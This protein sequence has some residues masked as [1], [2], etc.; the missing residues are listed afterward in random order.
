MMTPTIVV[1]ARPQYGTW[2][3]HPVGVSAALLAAIAGTK[4]LTPQTLAGAFAMGLPI[5]YVGD[6]G[7]CAAMRQDVEQRGMRLLDS[8]TP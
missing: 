3:W 2:A 7:A 4:T 8:V 5:V 6:E 1:H